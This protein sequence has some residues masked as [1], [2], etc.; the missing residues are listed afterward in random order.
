MLHEQLEQHRADLEAWRREELAKGAQ[1]AA[2]LRGDVGDP[3][4]L[5]LMKGAA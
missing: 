3:P 2:Y 1:I 4:L 5:A